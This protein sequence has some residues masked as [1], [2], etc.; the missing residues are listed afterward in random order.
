MFCVRSKAS[1]PEA[2]T[3]FKVSSPEERPMEDLDKR[4][5]I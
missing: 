3:A 5:V 1:M 2:L 4:S